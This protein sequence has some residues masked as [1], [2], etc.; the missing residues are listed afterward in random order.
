MIIA[1]AAKQK[2]RIAGHEQLKTAP[3]G[4]SK[5]H[6]RAELLRNKGLVAWQEWTPA[7]WLGTKKAKDRVVAFFHASEPLKEWLSVNVGESHDPR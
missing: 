3:R 2:I 1:A 4:Y 6:P 7:A 5:D